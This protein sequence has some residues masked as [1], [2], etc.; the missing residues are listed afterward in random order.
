M[1]LHRKLIDLLKGGKHQKHWP[2]K[3]FDHFYSQ[4]EQKARVSGAHVS[5]IYLF[6]E[7]YDQVISLAY[8]S[9]WSTNLQM[10]LT[11]QTDGNS[12]HV[13]IL[14]CETGRVRKGFI[15]GSVS[16]L[17]SPPMSPPSGGT[18]SLSCNTS[19]DSE[20]FKLN[21]TVCSIGPFKAATVKSL[22]RL[23]FIM[24]SRRF[25]E[26]PLCELFFRLS[27]ST[28]TLMP[29]SSARFYAGTRY[30]NQQII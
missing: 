6:G 1:R 22:S 4:I 2:L 28:Q 9:I 23:D 18:Q 12:N 19:M 27:A 3:N 17:L 14:D 16:A 25:L 7:N 21:S 13:S 20:F 29:T 11:L 24:V 5:K 8:Q 26:N 10:E 15:Q 30:R